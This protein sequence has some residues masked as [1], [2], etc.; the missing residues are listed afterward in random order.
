MRSTPAIFAAA[1]MA[2]SIFPSRPG[3]VVMTSIPQPAS[4]A[5]T[6]F[7]SRLEG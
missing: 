7:I 6:Q 2:G 3:G 1:R 4:F 5:G